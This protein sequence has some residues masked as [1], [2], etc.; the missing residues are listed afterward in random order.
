LRR[1]G[2][3]LGMTP[4]CGARSVVQDAAPRHDSRRVAV[5]GAA[6]AQFAANRPRAIPVRIPFRPLPPR[7]RP[8]KGRKWAKRLWGRRPGRLRARAAPRHDAQA[9]RPF[10]VQDAAPR[11]DSRRIAVPGGAAAQFAATRPRAIP[12][13]GRF[14]HFRPESGL[15]RGGSGRNGGTGGAGG[16]GSAARGAG[17]AARATARPTPWCRS[18]APGASRSA[19]SA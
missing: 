4:R 3:R 12:A 1:R 14:A 8:E 16:A 15:K 9:R 5:P 18:P 6:A 13:R 7:N 17:G 11:H 10:V 2:R 19:R